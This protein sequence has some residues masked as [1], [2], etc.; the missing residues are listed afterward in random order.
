MS[1]GIVAYAM[2]MTVVA[3]TAIL[4]GWRLVPK[5]GDRNAVLPAIVQDPDTRRADYL[6][7][8]SR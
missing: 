7:L 3:A 1:Q 8:W 2:L 4:A 6:F 5:E